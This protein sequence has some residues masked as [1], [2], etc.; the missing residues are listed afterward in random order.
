MSLRLATALAMLALAG[1]ALSSSVVLVDPGEVVV[2]RR[3]GRLLPR[4]WT[5]GLHLGLPFGLDRRDRVR[6][7]EVRR[8]DLGL[9]EVAGPEDEPSAGEFLTGDRNFVRLRAVVHYRVSGPAEFRLRTRDPER[10]LRDLAVSSLSRALSSR[11]IDG[12]LGPDRVSLANEAREAL[13]GAARSLDLG[14]TVQ[15][16]NLT[17]VR[18]P[19]E[20]DSAFAEAQAARSEADRRHREALAYEAALKPKAEAAASAVLDRAHALASASKAHAEAGAVRFRR[21][22]DASRSSPSLAARSLYLDTLRDLLGRVG[23]KVVLAP[24]EPVD[25]SLYEPR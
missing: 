9:V 20:V 19:R 16:V 25:L 12:V 4:P 1:F 2:I 23:R 3:L 13:E 8:L 24:D 17:D 5:S 11:G 22:L 7:D 14:V 18:P 10:L 21:L 6:V 15:E